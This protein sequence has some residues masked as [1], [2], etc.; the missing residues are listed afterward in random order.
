MHLSN[1]HAKCRLNGTTHTVVSRFDNG[2][3]EGTFISLSLS[4][5]LSE[6]LMIKFI[7]YYAGRVSN[8]YVPLPPR[9]T[10]DANSPTNSNEQKD[11][12]SPP[13]PHTLPQV[14]QQHNHHTIQGIIFNTHW[15]P[16]FILGAKII[17]EE[18]YDEMTPL[19]QCVRKFYPFIE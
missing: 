8:I 5:S 14:P 10:R 13:P 18:S 1:F 12:I 3:E 15:I 19:L 16:Q 6:S 11:F 4:L 2:Q 17:W 7:L 9:V